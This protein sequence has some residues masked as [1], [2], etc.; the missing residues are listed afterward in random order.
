MSSRVSDWL[1]HREPS[2][3]QSVPRRGPSPVIDLTADSDDD[4]DNGAS[5]SGAGEQSF[6]SAGSSPLS[7]YSAKTSSPLPEIRR[8]DAIPSFTST[9]NRPTTTPKAPSI[10]INRPS[11]LT[12]SSNLPSTPS[13][14]FASSSSAFMS[15][16]QRLNEDMRT[17]NRA[18]GVPFGVG[19]PFAEDEAQ[20]LE[21]MASL[22][23]SDSLSAGEQEKALKELVATTMD[24]D[25]VD[26]T[27]ETPA[28][29]KATLR[30]YQ[31]QGLHWLVDREK[32][33]KKRGGILGDD[34]GLG[35]TVQTIALMLAHRA[36]EKWKGRDTMKTTLIVCPVS[37]INQWADEIQKFSDGNLSVYLHHG[38][39]RYKAGHGRKFRKWDV[40]ITS[41]NTAASEWVDPKPKKAKGKGK[42]KLVEESD[43]DDEGGGA[44]KTKGALFDV[45]DEGGFYRI[46]LD[47]AHT[48]KNRNSRQHKAC[49]DLMGRFRWCLTGTPV[50]NEVWDLFSL[51]EFLGKIVSPL[52]EYGDFKA[53][54]ADPLKNKR[55]K[56]AMARLAVV[57]KAVMLRRRKDMLVDG[58][59]II[60]LPKREIIE[61]KGPFLNEDEQ[62]FYTAIET[63]MQ[64]SL[65]AFLKAGTAMAN[66]TSVLTLLLRMRQACSH[67]SLVTGN[68]IDD[69]EALETNVRVEK[70]G[71]ATPPSITA[72]ADDF[73][74]DGLIGGFGGLGV[75][76]KL[77]PL[78]NAPKKREEGEGE[79]KEPFC[80]K[81]REEFE[82]YGTLTFS[83]KIRRLMRI[84]EDVRG[85]DAGRKTIVFS[86][87]TSFF[88]L[89]EPFLKKAK[90]KFVRFDGKVPQPARVKVLDAIKNDPR[91]TIILISIKSGS[92]GLNLTCCSRVVLT[93]LWW[94]PAI[95]NQAFDRAH[96]MGQKEDVKIYKITVD[97]TIEDRILNLQTQKAELAKACIDGGDFKKGNKLSMKD[98]LY[99]F[100]S[101]GEPHEE[102]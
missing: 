34:M 91:T 73:D 76:E 85:E 26:T 2:T 100:K 4:S 38:S 61:V 9:S 60:V 48:I 57:L 49:C 81:C 45:E 20:V 43:E 12:N 25:D 66:Y 62:A 5:G 21:A 14:K 82:G 33:G 67:P 19:T 36:A 93:D 18:L 68:P 13:N 8:P 41:Y 46:I 78:C 23:V 89:V 44:V 63:K 6:V 80:G 7:V 51:F 54:I 64:L 37:L 35:K 1:H 3:P 75:Q 58:K 11:A 24:M 84:L 52:H 92:V 87:F 50:Q 101:D 86:Q 31:M 32:G 59:P 29:L 16:K 74:L 53:K 96:R 79:E 90:F 65:N 56:V 28:D 94:N 98:I 22:N 102:E 72:Q 70:P 30:P 55:A 71:T 15:V 99:L 39:D 69:R 88:D 27:L 77:C 42:A 97:N 17:Q 83:T 10:F 40:V 95:E 47:E